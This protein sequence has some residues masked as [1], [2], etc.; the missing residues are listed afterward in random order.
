MFVSNWN[1]VGIWV[2]TAG[3]TDLDVQGVDAE[4]LAADGDVLGSQHSSVWRGLVTVSLDLHTTSDTADGFATTSSLVSVDGSLGLS[5][6]EK[7]ER[8]E[9]RQTYERSVT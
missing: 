9:N 8:I 4:L 2:R 3:G 5:E 1:L 7:G 6:L